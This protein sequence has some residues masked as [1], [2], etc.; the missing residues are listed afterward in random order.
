MV[1]LRNS[2]NGSLD[3]KGWGRLLSD[4]L[5]LILTCNEH[6]A[7]TRGDMLKYVH[8]KPACYNICEKCTDAERVNYKK[9]L[10]RN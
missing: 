7:S 2:H 1:T 6:M 10:R 8:E 3:S 4:K 5:I 9:R